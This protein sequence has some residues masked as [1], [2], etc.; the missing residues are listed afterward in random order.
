MIRT[1]DFLL[2]FSAIMFLLT[3]I[4][5]TVFGRIHTNVQ[6]ATVI[7]FVTDTREEFSAEIPQS[8][9]I[10]REDRLL[11]MRQK[12][13]DSEAQPWL[14]VEPEPIISEVTVSDEDEENQQDIVVGISKCSNYFTYRGVW[15]PQEIQSSV[16][17]GARIFYRE[18]IVSTPQDSTSSPTELQQEV[19]L[20]L[21]LYPLINTQSS[22]LSSDVVGIAQDGSLIRHNES[23]LYSVFGESTLIGYA[24]D[25]FPIYGVTDVATDECG[26]VVL[27]GE[28]RYHLS[29]TRDSVLQCF[30]A[31]PTPL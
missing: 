16:S 9:T 26:G 21:P 10:S 25:G 14:E 3:A 30:R 12:I 11:S 13:A 28:Y 5:G 2:I 27:A 6:T 17:E 8:E 23:G 22:C 4:G 18:I 31:T 15:A 1:R 7:E 19:I 20:Q 24:L 29:E